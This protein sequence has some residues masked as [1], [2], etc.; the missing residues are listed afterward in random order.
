MKT[1]LEL[2]WWKSGGQNAQHCAALSFAERFGC[3]L[4]DAR[5][6]LALQVEAS[7]LLN[8]SLCPSLPYVTPEEEGA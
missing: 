2:Q 4:A 1:R 5:R 6:R 8:R 7:E 3:S